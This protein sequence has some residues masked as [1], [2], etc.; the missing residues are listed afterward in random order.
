MSLYSLLR[1]CYIYFRFL[2]K[3]KM[4]TMVCLL[5]S[6]CLEG[7][8]GVDSTHR[9][10]LCL[11]WKKNPSDQNPKLRVDATVVEPPNYSRAQSL[12]PAFV[13]AAISGPWTQ[14]RRAEASLSPIKVTRLKPTNATDYCTVFLLWK[15]H[16]TE[17][18]FS[19]T[20]A[21]AVTLQLACFDFPKDN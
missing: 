19:P 20:M 21:C 18:K 8:A 3:L 4:A 1:A 10:A 7:S 13:G 6:L 2:T 12:L 11:A 15:S 9:T 16:Q 14:A 5:P 17:V